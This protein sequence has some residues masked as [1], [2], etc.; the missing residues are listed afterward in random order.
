MQASPMS[1]D[2]TAHRDTGLGVLATEKGR[3]ADEERSAPKVSDAL[4]HAVVFVVS[5]GRLPDMVS[6]HHHPAVALQGYNGDYSTGK[7]RRDPDASV[8]S[9]RSWGE[10]SLPSMR[11]DVGKGTR[12]LPDCH[13]GVTYDKMAWP[14]C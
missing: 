6:L 12:P 14:C 7:S 13:A 3:L 9:G 2:D 11:D 8:A 5:L 10:D 4:A 1:A